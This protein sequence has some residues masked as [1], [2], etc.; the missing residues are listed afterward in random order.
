MASFKDHL[1]DGTII[2]IKADTNWGTPSLHLSV[3]L[4]M[5]VLESLLWDGNLIFLFDC[6]TYSL[7]LTNLERGGGG[8]EGTQE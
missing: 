5:K 4:N 7:H 6:S 8:T 2:I 1:K 3:M